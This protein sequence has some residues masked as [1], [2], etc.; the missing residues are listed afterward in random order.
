[1]NCG[2]DPREAIR[3]QAAEA[4]VVLSDAAVEEMAIHLED[5]YAAARNDGASEEEARTSVQQA[6]LES[7]FAVL[8]R[9]RVAN[10]ERRRAQV[11]EA[12]AVTS[13]GRSLNVLSAVRLAIRQFSQHKTFAAVT[14][15]VLGLGTGAAATVFSVVDSVVLRPLPYAQPDR[16][17]TLWDTNHERGLAHDPISPVNF[18]DYRALPVFADAAAWWRPSINL[19]D[20]GLDP[21]R[22][23]TI[24]VSGNVFTVLGVSPQL[25]QGFPA[26]RLFVPRDPIA[27]ISDGSGE[28]ATAPTRRSSAASSCSMAART[29]SPG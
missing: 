14:V 6:V 24:E 13:G 21:V 20:P 8:Q 28:P 4:G 5:L 2:V 25:G 9:H 27:T 11:A 22:V 1:M 17:V 29:P 23:N 18:M 3:R 26:D 16:L 12:T 15:L 19:T 10:A 7:P